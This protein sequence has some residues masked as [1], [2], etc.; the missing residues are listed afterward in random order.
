M[1]SVIL[2]AAMALS[3]S[4]VAMAQAGMTLNGETFVARTVTDAAGNKKNELQPATKVLPGDALVLMQKWKNE[5][6]KPV[7]GF[8]INSPV[9]KATV[10]SGSPQPAPE[11]SVDGGKTFGALAALKV[12]NA[13]GSLRAAVPQ[14]VTN[15][16]WTMAQAIPAGASGSVAYFAV[17]K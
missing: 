12:K 14:D 5:T 9:P 7:T 10:F 11:V 3:L 13:D 16:R 4:T 2:G 17:V 15:V 8:V 1:K 6:G